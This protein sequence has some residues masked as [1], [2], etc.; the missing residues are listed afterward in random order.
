MENQ[1]CRRARENKANCAKQT[2]FGPVRRRV[3]SQEVKKLGA[4]RHHTGTPEPDE[5]A[6]DSIDSRGAPRTEGPSAFRGPPPSVFVARAIR[7]SPMGKDGRR[8][9]QKDRRILFF[10]VPGRQA[11]SLGW[12][13]RPQGS[14]TRTV[15]IS[16]QEEQS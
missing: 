3:R 7:F 14:L 10:S 15:R 4:I 9:Y 13:R 8:P 1:A 5:R 11:D 6:T 16:S 12:N 2:Q